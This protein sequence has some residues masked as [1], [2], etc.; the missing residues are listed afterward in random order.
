MLYALISSAFYAVQNIACK[1]YGRRFSSRARGLTLMLFFAMLV[2]CAAMA[3]VGGAAMIAALPML[4]AAAF[5]GTFVLTFMCMTK[6]M[7]IGPL[8]VTTLIGNS[9]LVVTSCVGMAFW[10][11]QMTWCKGIGTLLILFMLA[12]SAMS[13]KG[14]QKGGAKWLALALL[15][16]LGNVVLS[17]IQHEVTAIHGVSANAFNF[18]SSAFSALFCLLGLCALRLTGD[19]SEWTSRLGELLG[20]A[21]GVGLGTA[22]GNALAIVVL[23]HLPAVVAFPVRQGVLVLMM[24]AAGRLIY[25]DKPGKWDALILISGLAGIVLMNL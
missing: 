23:E 17:V 3:V 4:L 13:S 5:G 20:C 2:Q 25:H 18:W 15:F 21:A 6:A 16:L 10:G 12:L 19:I 7:A 8:G 11:E 9:S 14:G 1:E 22:G 24:W